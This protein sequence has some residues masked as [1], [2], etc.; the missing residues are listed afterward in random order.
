MSYCEHLTGRKRSIC[1]GTSGLPIEQERAYVERWIARGDIP[2]E[3]LLRFGDRGLG[4][5]IKRFTDATGITK[6]AKVYEK[7][8]GKTCGC[9]GRQKK[10]NEWFPYEASDP[11]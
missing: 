4:D 6:I 11:A 8:T 9:P 2:E 5:T 3:A 10:L 1:E 7:V